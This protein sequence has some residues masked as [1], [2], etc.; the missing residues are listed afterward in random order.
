MKC[1]HCELEF[2][3]HSKEKKEVGGFINECPDCV[4][5]L[6]GDRTPK[7]L[8]V[9]AGNGKMS[10][11]TILKFDNYED[12]KAY[13]N[14][15]KNNS[16]LNKGKSCQLGKHLTSMSGMSFKIVSENRANDNHKGKE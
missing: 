3:P 14:A 4:E 16:G 9:A 11:V 15:W 6:G 7:Y 2:N 8:G 13:S 1:K 10:D 5:E 12:R